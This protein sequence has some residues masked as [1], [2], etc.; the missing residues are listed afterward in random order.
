MNFSVSSPRPT[1][2]N[3]FFCAFMRLF[4]CGLTHRKINFNLREHNFSVRVRPTEKLFLTVNPQ[5]NSIF[6][7]LYFCGYFSEGT[8]SEKYFSDGIR[9]FLCVFA[10]TEK[11]EI[12]VVNRAA[13]LLLYF[14]FRN[15]LT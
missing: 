10:P 6:L 2:K 1:E 14:L 13:S 9:I 4:L 11:S 3:V 5:K 8:P 7:S 12:P 15:L